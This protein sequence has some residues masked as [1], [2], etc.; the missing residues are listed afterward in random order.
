[1]NNQIIIGSIL[2]DI[3]GSQY[4]FSNM[5]PFDLDWENV[6]LFTDK[7]R[8]TDDTILTLATK[9]AIQLAQKEGRNPIPQDFINMYQYFGCKYNGG[10]GLMFRK[11]LH[12]SNPQPYNSYGNGSAMRCSP[13]G[14]YYET[15]KDIIKYANMSAGVT[16]NHPQG[17]KGAVVISKCILMAKQGKTKDEIFHYVLPYYSSSSYD[18][19]V[20]ESLK[21]MRG[22]YKWDVTCQ[23]SVPAA[24]VCFFESCDW[25]SF[26][27]NV[28]SLPCDMDTLGAIGGGVAAA[29]Y[30]KT[31]DNYDEILQKYL[32]EELYNLVYEDIPFSFDFH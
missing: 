3:S 17:R 22:H 23:G 31:V 8:Y 32:P 9:K 29:F 10:Y 4:E 27:R 28:M 2:G 30:G 16:H 1:M 5:R 12:S 14:A 6:P 21:H 11:W 24:L 19:P 20:W 15:E 26:M 18:Y 13:I 7:C 25:E